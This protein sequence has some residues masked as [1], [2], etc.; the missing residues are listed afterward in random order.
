MVVCRHLLEKVNRGSPSDSL[1][2]DRIYWGVHLMSEKS[3]KGFATTLVLCVLL[4][5]LGVHRFYVGKIGTGIL[6]LLTLGGLGI[7]QIIDLIVI[8]TQNFKDGQGLP[9]KTVGGFS[10]KK[11]LI[12]VG[13]GVGGFLVL[14]LVIVLLPSPTTEDDRDQPGPTRASTGRQPTNTPSRAGSSQPGSSTLQ[15]EAKQLA[16][17]TIEQEVEVIEAAIGQS[18]KDLS[19][20]LV[21]MPGTDRPRAQNLGDNFVRL[22][23]TF[24]PE[25]PPSKEIGRGTFH[26][27]ITVATPDEKIIAQGAKVSFSPRLT[28]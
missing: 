16:I 25:D 2:H 8:A 3:A 21:V 27:L 20:A 26:Y 7:W 17:M 22:V 14:V 6:M 9:I 18:G 19:L 12:W 28:W 5:Q 11:T 4:G 23:K 15:A 10:K 1:V 24:G 13:S